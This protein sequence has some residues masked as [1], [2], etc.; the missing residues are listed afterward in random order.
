MNTF[1]QNKVVAITGGSDGIGKAIIEALLPLEAKIATCGRNADKLN[2]L[3]ATH[4]SI[5]TVVADVSN[6]N[7]CKNFIDSTIATYGGIDILINNAGISMRALLQE[8]DIDVIKKVM[9]IN[10]YGTV[11]CTKLALN[12]IIER[13]GTIVGVSSVAGYR[14]LP[15]RTGYSASKFAV[16]GFLESLRTELLETGVNVMWVCPGFTASNIRNAA[17]V[18]DGSH[19]GQT[20]L[21]EHSLMTAEECAA[22][23]LYAIAKR[24]RT[25]IY[26]TGDKRTVWLNKLFPGLTDKLVRNFFYKNGTLVK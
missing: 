20:P 13:K 5:L 1:F 23:T 17:L 25:L 9:D 6:Y 10:F 26:T 2:A 16:N 19:Q 12:T 14:G 3:K 7:D 8:T 24:K 22:I 4:P 18:K 11:H 15:A 21:D